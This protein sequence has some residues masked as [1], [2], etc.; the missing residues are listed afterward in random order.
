MNCQI[1]INSDLVDQTNQQIFKTLENSLNEFINF[2]VWTNKSILINEK[3]SCSFIINLSSYNS[4][5]FVGTLQVQSQRP[6]H[7]SNYD[8]PIFNL[9]DKDISFKYQ[10]FEPLFYNPNSYQSNLISLV[11]FY[12]YIILGIQA[13]S[14]ENFSGTTYYNEAFRILNFSQKSNLKGWNQSDGKR[15]RFWLIDSLLS[16]AYIEFRSILYSYH[17]L[18]LDLM[19]ENTRVGKNNIIKSL[20][21]FESLYARR[22]NSYLIQVFFDAKSNEIVDIFSEGPKVEFSN[23][24]NVLNNVAPF[25]SHQ[26]KKIKY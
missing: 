9:L 18:G 11:S 24:I 16:N 3:I 4:S 20:N 5:N 2:N 17:H 13:D 12:I 19:V 6:I 8:S 21:S 22:P 15:N 23:T 7:N 1:V 25:F 26:W 14:F 10:E